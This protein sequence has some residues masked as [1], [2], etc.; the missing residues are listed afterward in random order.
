[1]KKRATIP[2][3]PSVVKKEA[4]KKACVEIRRKKQ[5]LLDGQIQQQKLLLKKFEAAETPAEKESIRS[6]MKQ[7]DATIIRL[8]DSFQTVPVKAPAAPKVN[9]QS[10]LKQR[11]QA[12]QKQLE[13]LRAKTSADMV[14]VRFSSS[15]YSHSSHSFQ[16]RSIA[17]TLENK[18]AEPSRAVNTKPHDEVMDRSCVRRLG[19]SVLTSRSL[20]RLRMTKI[21]YWLITPSLPSSTNSI[22]RTMKPNCSILN[23]VFFS[24]LVPLWNSRLE[25]IC[26][27]M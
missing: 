23:Q 10:L 13:R 18:I 1:M 14:S 26:F 8:K 12:L 20:F 22:N 21:I 27:C 5:D 3:G 7:V 2:S 16:R 9:Q 17:T 24:L 15:F 6:L 25:L 11:E 4:A 19:I